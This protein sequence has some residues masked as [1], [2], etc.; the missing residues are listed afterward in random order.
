MNR[1]FFCDLKDGNHLEGHEKGT[2]GANPMISK[3][4]L[5]GKKWSAQKK[6]THVF[7]SSQSQCQKKMVI[8]TARKTED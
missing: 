7:H 8:V 2:G 5:W 4:H 3:Y 1:L 6:N